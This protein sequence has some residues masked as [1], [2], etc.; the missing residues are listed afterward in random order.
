MTFKEFF[1]QIESWISHL[2]HGSVG[3][4][5]KPYFAHLEVWHIVSLFILGGCMIL[6]NLR[7]LGAGLTPEPPS[8]I[9]KNVRPW[10]H[11]GVFGV[12]TSGILIGFANAEK[13]Y[14]STAFTAKMVSLVAAIIFT[15][16]VC[17]PTAKADG[18]VGKVAK[19]GAALAMIIWVV[20]LWIF[21]S[22]EGLAPGI[23]LVI[24]AAGLM[25]TATL[26]GR[27][28]W[29]YLAGLA[30]IIIA[31][32]IVTHSVVTLDSSYDNWVVANQWFTRAEALWIVGF[33]GYQIFGYRNELAGGPLTRIIG[34]SSL[35]VWVTVAAAGRWIAFAS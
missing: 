2:E 7:L 26:R 8:V 4:I 19:I 16:V 15:Y 27:V 35:L 18:R 21:T 22:I 9:E 14:D 31:H 33:G 5:F 34:F 24:L 1:P 28:R 11:F 10:L 23:I 6:I 17:T 13:L 3:P 20:S 25:V 30:A 29:I 32:Q 12:L